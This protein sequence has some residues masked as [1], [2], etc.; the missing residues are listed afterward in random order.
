MGEIGRVGG[1]GFARSLELDLH[2]ESGGLRD[3]NLDV[4]AQIEWREQA[5][6]FVVPIWAPADD[7]Q[8]EIDLA[9]CVAA[10]ASA[11]GSGPQ[12]HLLAST[13]FMCSS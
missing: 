3:R 7:A 10:Q 8:A 11:R 13:N 6:E 4:I 9:R 2:L 12:T 5:L 1:N